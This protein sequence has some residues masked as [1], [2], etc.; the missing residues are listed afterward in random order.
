MTNP[1]IIRSVTLAIGAA[2][3][4]P[5]AAGV[6]ATVDAT[7]AAACALSGWPGDPDP[8]GPNIRAAPR[9]NAEVIGRVPPESNGYAAEFEIAGSSNGWFL[10][11]GV[12]FRDYDVW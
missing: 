11:N 8:A 12:K 1:K 6:A 10:I 9:A 2:C 7:V 5:A 3:F 4:F